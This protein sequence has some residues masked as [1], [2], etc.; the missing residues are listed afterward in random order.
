MEHGGLLVNA[1][2]YLAAA[3]I[4]VPLSKRIGLGSIL[5]YLLAGVIIGPWGLGLITDV[6]DI[7]HFSEFGV[8]LMLFLIGLELNPSKLWSMRKPIL[9]LGGGQV[10][11]SALA[12]AGA[13][14]LLGHGLSA[15]IVAGMG[16]ALSSTAVALQTL[17]EK[18]L[19]GTLA[20]RSAFPVLLFQDIAVIPMLAIVPLL[21]VGAVETESP[22]G[23]GW[24][25]ALEILGVFA[26]II[27]G[28]RY[29][30]RPIFRYIANTRMREIFTAF[31]L[32]LVIGIALL[33]QMV[34]LS[35]ALGTF[36][37]GVLLADSEY[38][39]ELE[40]NIEPFKGLLLGLFFISVGMSVDLSVLLASPLLV[41]GMVLGLV[42]IKFLIL[43]GIGRFAKMD[44]ADRT[45]FSF[46]LSQGGEFGFVLFAMAESAGIFSPEAKALFVVTVA[47]SM[48]TTPLLMLFNDR[49]LQ[50]RFHCANEP[51]SDVEDEGYDVIIAGYGRFGQIVGRLLHSL[52]IPFTVLESDPN[53]I[54]LLR[55]FGRKAFYGDASRLDL[56]E[57][58]GA[59]H[60]KLLVLAID[61][62][63]S[64][65]E[66]AR[67]AKEHFP[68]LRILAR[69]RNRT[70]A[71]ELIQLGVDKV[72]R[73]T[74]G[75]AL[76]MGEKTL[77]ELG[78]SEEKAKRAAEIF[79][80]HDKRN[81]TKL[82]SLEMEEDEV[83]SYAAQARAELEQ[84]MQFD[85]DE[86]V[87]PN[88]KQPEI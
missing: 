44:G 6:E 55:K 67:L 74:F 36:L 20:G 32:L 63:E 1:V 21:A 50:G 45:V 14:S 3:V 39:H 9:A 51:A 33:M 85:E 37:A 79:R 64:L 30:L 11:L 73:E 28:G 82:A 13:V 40:I 48:L 61:D 35:M 2:I 54:E 68:N 59:G 34:D 5:G 8:V 71:V 19:M 56:L 38:R 88:G 52:K 65:L 17:E 42:A 75:S 86:A 57:T 24:I 10:L 41:L 60:A 78:F 4:A 81:V 16:L 84:L 66:T 7:L 69:A 77:L 43:L 72:S 76:E 25:G 46:V 23:A 80:A 22:A 15:A 53:Q 87:Q 18:K 49:V 62:H 26:G 29:L 27:I 70:V 31:A 47:L 12:L 83:Y 58:A